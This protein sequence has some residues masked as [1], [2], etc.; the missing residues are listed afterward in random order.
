MMLAPSFKIVPFY[1]THILFFVDFFLLIFDFFLKFKKIRKTRI[2]LTLKVGTEEPKD[3][4]NCLKAFYF[5]K[6]ISSSLLPVYWQ[7]LLDNFALF[8][9]NKI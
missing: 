1:I 6:N 4:N 2:D 7:F 3:P 9:S 5:P 8:L